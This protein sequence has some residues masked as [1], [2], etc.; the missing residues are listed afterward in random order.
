MLRSWTGTEQVLGGRSCGWKISREEELHLHN[1]IH[2]KAQAV[3]WG[4]NQAKRTTHPFFTFRRKEEREQFCLIAGI[5]SAWSFNIFLGVEYY[6]QKN[7]RGVAPSVSRPSFNTNQNL[8]P[9]QWP[10]EKKEYWLKQVSYSLPAPIWTVFFFLSDWVVLM[11]TEFY[12]TSSRYDVQEEIQADI[13]LRGCAG[14]VKGLLWNI[15]S[16]PLQSRGITGEEKNAHKTCTRTIQS[17]TKTPPPL[18]WENSAVLYRSIIKTGK[19]KKDQD[20]FWAEKKKWGNTEYSSHFFF[21]FFINWEFTLLV[22][23]G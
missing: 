5:P 12:R 22:V 9:V 1:T 15:L 4:S 13:V 18:L 19:G 14:G 21:L 20:N 23:A 7:C 11:P 6:K 17:A 3:H 2:P 16:R 8:L 10:S